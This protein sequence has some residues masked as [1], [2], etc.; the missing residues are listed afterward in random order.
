MQIVIIIIVLTYHQHFSSSFVSKLTVALM[1]LLV[2]LLCLTDRRPHG[3]N[4][5]SRHKHIVRVLSYIPRN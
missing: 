1:K 3:V 2:S 4:T 5:H